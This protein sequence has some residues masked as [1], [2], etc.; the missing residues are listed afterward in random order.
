MH[1]IELDIFSVV[2]EVLFK[3]WSLFCTN[4]FWV[5]ITGLGLAELRRGVWGRPGSQDAISSEAA[6]PHLHMLPIVL[7]LHISYALSTLIL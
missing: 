6:G 7:T 1:R 5:A 4:R 2:I 3:G